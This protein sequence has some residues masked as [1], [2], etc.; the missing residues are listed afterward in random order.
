MPPCKWGW[1]DRE[2]RRLRSSALCQHTEP[3]Q[4]NCS[5]AL[6]GGLGA[7]Y[8]HYNYRGWALHK[9]QVAWPALRVR[10]SKYID[11]I[12]V[13]QLQRPRVLLAPSANQYQSYRTCLDSFRA[14]SIISR[15]TINWLSSICLVTHWETR[16]IFFAATS[17]W[18]MSSKTHD[19]SPPI[20]TSSK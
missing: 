14:P 11:P 15:L 9:L 6:T 7:I 18:M 19:A 16:P 13:A 12:I 1:N 4:L 20:V 5:I 10:L 2:Y 8:I 3:Y 17:S